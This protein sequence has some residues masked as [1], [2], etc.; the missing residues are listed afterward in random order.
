MLREL[1]RRGGEVE[2]PEPGSVDLDDG[3]AV[4]RDVVP[5][6]DPVDL[7]PAF[8]VPPLAPTAEYCMMSDIR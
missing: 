8:H 1:R 2:V 3:L 4:P 7:R 6:L 5:E